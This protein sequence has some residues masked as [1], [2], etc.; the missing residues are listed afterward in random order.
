MKKVMFVM[1]IV[2]FLFIS[3]YSLTISE[4]IKAWNQAPPFDNAVGE[5]TF[6]VHRGTRVYE[7]ELYTIQNNRGQNL[8]EVTSPPND[9]GKLFYMENDN[10]WIF[11]ENNLL[12][13]KGFELQKSFLGSDI[14]YQ[15]QISFFNIIKDANIEI[16]EDK[17]EK[18]YF[19]LK[20]NKNRAGKNIIKYAFFYVYRDTKSVYQVDLYNNNNN[21]YK[22]ITLSDFRKYNGVYFPFYKKIQD[23][24][25]KKNYTEVVIDDMKLNVALPPNKMDLYELQKRLEKNPPVFK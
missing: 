11:D 10:I 12:N 17:T 9:A 18:D 7:Y 3:V 13:I 4:V 14:T 19:I 22:R 25:V 5:V 24:L 1:L 2:S 8:I 15:E 23:M 16:F 20:V 21:L 6:K